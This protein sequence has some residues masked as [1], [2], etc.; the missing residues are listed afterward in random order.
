MPCWRKDLKLSKKRL[1]FR[2][3]HE[4]TLTKLC[5]CKTWNYQMCLNPFIWWLA[6]DTYLIFISSLMHHIIILLVLL[7]ELLLVQLICCVFAPDRINKIAFVVCFNLSCFLDTLKLL[8]LTWIFHYENSMQ[9]Y[10]RELAEAREC[11]KK[12]RITGKDA[13][14]TQVLLP[15]HLIISLCMTK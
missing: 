10:G 12:Y 6:Y 4:N 2:Y 11:C 9:A 15:S 14:L 8:V 1:S 7:I 13:E 3:F 5:I